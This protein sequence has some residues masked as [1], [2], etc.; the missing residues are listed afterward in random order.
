ME[1]DT[2][3]QRFMYLAILGDFF[4]KVVISLI[5]LWGLMEVENLQLVFS[6]LSSQ[7]ARCPIGT[8]EDVE[9]D[10]Q[11]LEI[12]AVNYSQ[13]LFKHGLHGSVILATSERGKNLI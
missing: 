11:L 4:I 5:L 10:G 12:P 2:I 9:L 1:K 8:K 13:P 6:S 7:R 3:S